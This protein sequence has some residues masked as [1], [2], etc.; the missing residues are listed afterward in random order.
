MYRVLWDG[1]TQSL[2]RTV[3]YCIHNTAI[4]GKELLTY[5]W[6][7]IYSL[8]AGCNELFIRVIY[9][10]AIDSTTSIFHC[11]KLYFKNIF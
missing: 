8:C 10:C 6:C 1:E 2:R 4:H 9:M 3:C 11:A 7:I 5:Q